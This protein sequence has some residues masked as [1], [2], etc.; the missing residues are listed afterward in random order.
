MDWFEK[1][2]GFCETDYDDIDLHAR[3]AFG[4]FQNDEKFGEVMWKFKPSAASHV[5]SN[6]GP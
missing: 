6:S 1:L 5:P 2:T 4:A 3:K